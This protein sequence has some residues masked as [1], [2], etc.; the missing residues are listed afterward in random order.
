MRK[1]DKGLPPSKTLR[2]LGPL[3]LRAYLQAKLRCSWSDAQLS[4]L[5]LCRVLRDWA[6]TVRCSM[7]RL[8]SLTSALSPMTS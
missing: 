8:C 6:F 2:E 4:A 1:A 5:C 3:A 7:F